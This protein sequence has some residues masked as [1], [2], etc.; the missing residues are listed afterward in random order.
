MKFLIIHLLLVLVS[1]SA[2][3]GEL[4]SKDELSVNMLLGIS[5]Y[6]LMQIELQKKEH[7]VGLGFPPRLF[8]RHFS[9]PDSNSLFFGLYCGARHKSPHEFERTFNGVVYNDKETED[10]GFGIGHRWQWSSGWNLSASFSIHYA[11]DE[12]T[13]S[14]LPKKI[15]NFMILF[16]GLNIGYKF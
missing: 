4:R 11:H 9:K 7:S 2:L 12:Y 3:S 14:G 8:Y 6:G 13:K 1:G 5:P 16:P 15:D 10:A